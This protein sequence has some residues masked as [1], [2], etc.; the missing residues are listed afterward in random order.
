MVE[1]IYDHVAHANNRGKL[2][3]ERVTPMIILFSGSMNMTTMREEIEKQIHEFFG[4]INYDVH[5]NDD[6]AS[7][8]AS[9]A[10]NLA[11]DAD[12]LNPKIPA[13]RKHNSLLFVYFL[14]L[15]VFSL[16][17]RGY[18]T[19]IETGFILA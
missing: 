5:D 3:R 10:S 18:K 15:V 4:N 16:S 6:D 1:Y 12:Y 7:I 2:D 8:Q 14:R 13:T 9:L 11:I 17:I 19:E